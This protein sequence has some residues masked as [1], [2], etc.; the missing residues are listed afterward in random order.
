[1]ANVFKS[2]RDGA[3]TCSMTASVIN[4]I[5]MIIGSG[6]LG[7]PWAFGQTGMLLG[8]SLLALIGAVQ[9]FTLHL[10]AVCVMDAHRHGEDV[11]FRSLAVAAF[12][13]SQSMDSVVEVL[14]CILCFGGGTSFLIVTGDLIPQVCDYFDVREPWPLS[15]RHFWITAVGFCVELPLVCCQRLES[16]KV[17]SVVGNVGVAYIVVAVAIFASGKLDLE[18]PEQPASLLPP[19]ETAHTSFAGMV[20][21]IPIYIFAYTCVPNIPRLVID[22]QDATMRR[23]DM[24]LAAAFGT[25]FLIFLALGWFGT[26][27]FGASVN[28]NLLKSFPSQQGTTGGLV[29]TV[30]RIATVLNV[31]GCF[32]LYMHPARE[33]LSQLLFQKAPG[34]L[35]LP[36]WALVTAGLFLGSWGVAMTVDTL[37]VALSFVGATACM[38]IGFSLPATLHL[39][40]R[41][42]QVGD[43]SLPSECLRHQLLA[44]DG[45]R[46][47]GV[48]LSS[49]SKGVSGELKA[50]DVA[51][52]QVMKGA[53]RLTV[54][55]SVALVPLLVTMQVVLM[56][57]P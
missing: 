34:D 16:L 2:T 1:M 6:I 3:G 38:L 53:A 31:V 47:Y 10:L 44:D 43:C 48:S 51:R 21:C 25:C 27:A 11:S 41:Q 12:Q 52:G 24:M 46:R 56:T 23:V 57:K 54:V 13:G 9:A 42:G 50:L 45:G 15:D 55:V 30:A 17:S 18:A 28:P 37:E 35:A 33:S 40:L 39:R 4:L 14:V 32:P 49:S 7:V 5:K 29:A 19:P 20:Q 8:A 22:L 26:E 36:A